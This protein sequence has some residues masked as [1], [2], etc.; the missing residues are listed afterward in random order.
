MRMSCVHVIKLHKIC[1]IQTAAAVTDSVLCFRSN[2]GFERFLT[3]KCYSTFELIAANGN[4]RI[5]YA[6]RCGIGFPYNRVK[7][8]KQV[9]PSD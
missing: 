3:R 6:I 5:A 4:S 2:D 7:R 9:K 8:F 1:V